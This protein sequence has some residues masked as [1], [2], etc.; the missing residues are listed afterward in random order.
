MTLVAGRLASHIILN[1][2]YHDP[3]LGRFISVDPLVSVTHDAYGY[4]NN[5]PITHSDPTGLCA[6]FEAR[7]NGGCGGGSS[8][9]GGGEIPPP[10]PW[11]SDSKPSSWMDKPE[12]NC[13]ERA[14][15]QA[16]HF[17][18][19]PVANA[20]IV[21]INAFI[22]TKN[23]GGW[24]LPSL[25]DNRDFGQDPGDCSASRACLVLDLGR[26]TGSLV[27]TYSCSSSTSCADAWPIGGDN[28]FINIS[29]SGPNNTLTVAV[30]AEHSKT[31]PLENLNPLT[32]DFSAKFET[33]GKYGHGVMA[34]L[35]L[36]AF[37]SYE[38]F[39]DA[40]SFGYKQAPAVLGVP[41]A[42]AIPFTTTQYLPSRG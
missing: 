36:E 8:G 39:T 4:G 3:T 6:E 27:V 9:G 13:D 37:P 10:P 5:N 7:L 41:L 40:G 22:M 19:K 35:Q 34:T 2:R 38:I 15:S 1:N 28:N 26:G 12:K 31:S 24:V 30:S 21:R 32:V 17:G 11:S 20:G 29:Q 18:F 25:G 42:L 16:V 14:C 23:I 33:G